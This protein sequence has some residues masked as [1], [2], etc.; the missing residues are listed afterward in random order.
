M[1]AIDILN[2]TE[3]FAPIASAAD[4]DNCGILVG[5]EEQQVTKALLA[6]DITPEVVEE[7]H[8]KGAELIISHHPVI[9]RPLKRVMTGTAVYQLIKYGITALCL[10]TN[11]DLSPVFGVNTELARVLGI[12]DGHFAEGTFAYIGQLEQPTTAE[13]FARRVNRELDCRG[14]RYTDKEQVQKICV[15][16]GAGA[17]EVF[18]AIENGCDLFLTGEMKHH[19]FVEAQNH[20]IAVIEAGHFSSEDV[21]MKP[22]MELLQS[23]FTQISFEMTECEVVKYKKL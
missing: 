3:T 8:T 19:L 23:K 15:S 16:G 12:R 2:Y 13:E 21:V 10:H 22:L 9:F 18:T 11:L 6:L 20:G 7:A 17:E 5:D 14:L 4:F 1:K